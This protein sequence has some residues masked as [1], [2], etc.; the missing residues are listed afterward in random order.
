MYARLGLVA[1]I[2]LSLVH[3]STAHAE[4]AKVEP[5]PTINTSPRVYEMGLFSKDVLALQEQMKTKGVMPPAYWKDVA[6]CETA[7]NWKDKGKWGGGLGIATT[8]WRGFGG[9]EFA[10]HPSEATMHE[11]MFVANRIS[12]FGYQ[13]K[14]EFLT[15][16][17][18]QNNR[19]FFRP[20][21]GFFGWGCIANNRYL[22]P[23]NW[24]D[25]NRRLWLQSKKNVLFPHG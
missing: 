2:T 9:Y 10:K 18:K 22:H 23:K 14:R 19:P 11:Q 12:V 3:P 8:T 15:L 1:C 20:K 4:E 25:N 24:R 5:K 21:A 16:E 6:Q 17:D 7:N 13:T